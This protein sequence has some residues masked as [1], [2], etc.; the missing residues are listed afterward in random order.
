MLFQC[1]Y[2]CIVDNTYPQTYTDSTRAG[3]CDGHELENGYC[4]ACDMTIDTAYCDS[5][6]GG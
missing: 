6:S 4:G 3:P 2:Y 1:E 5:C